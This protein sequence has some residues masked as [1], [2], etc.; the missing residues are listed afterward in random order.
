ML[1]EQPQSTVF[2]GFALVRLLLLPQNGFAARFADVVRVQAG[3]GEPA[4]PVI[5]LDCSRSQEG[6]SWLHVLPSFQHEEEVKANSFFCFLIQ[7]VIST[8]QVKSESAEEVTEE[9]RLLPQRDWNL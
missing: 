4:G 9:E 5:C 1:L 2:H 6:R 3:G 8:L 7:P